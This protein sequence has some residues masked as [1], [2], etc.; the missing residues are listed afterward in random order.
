MRIANWVAAAGL[1]TMLLEIAAVTLGELVNLIDVV[2][3]LLSER[4]VKVAMPPEAVTVVVP[5]NGPEPTGIVA[6]VTWVALS[7]VIQV[8]VL[9]FNVDHGL[10]A[11]D[12]AGRCRGRRLRA[13]GQMARGRRADHD[14]RGG[15]RGKYRRAREV[16][17]D[18]LGLVVRQVGER[19]DA[20]RGRDRRRP[21]ER[22]RATGQRS[23][24]D[25]GAVVA[26]LEIAELVFDVDD[27]LSAEGDA[28]RRRGRRLSV[29]HQLARR[30]RADDD[31]V[32]CRCGEYRRRW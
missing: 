31:V 22:A 5:C 4:L 7:V 14:A 32:G 1:T 16:D 30:R 13:H 19:G 3:A 17:R 27:R 9:V 15:H 29:D 23:G 12:D 18:G 26:G 20:A 28:G 21:L 25:C 8:A 10:R 11:E 24:S 2:S 6:A